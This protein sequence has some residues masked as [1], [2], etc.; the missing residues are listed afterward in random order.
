[1]CI[2]KC[3]TANITGRKLKV[4]AKY[5]GLIRKTKWQPDN[6]V[7]RNKIDPLINKLVTSNGSLTKSLMEL[8][9]ELSVNVLS[10]NLAL[11]LNHEQIL[12]S[13]PLQ[14]RAIVRQ[15]ELNVDENI[16]VFARS[17]LPLSLI[18]KTQ[19]GLANLG[20]KPLGHLLFKKGEMRVSKRQFAIMNHQ[21]RVIF[22]RR[23]PYEYMDST[24]LV[25][26]YFL[27]NV[28]QLLTK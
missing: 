23:T 2:N 16:V 24:I 28:E 25:S 18:K 11:P 7:T 19:T 20:Q 10:Q 15:V 9:T 14:K 6:K 21:G 5:E 22:A 13:R 17:I 1:M 4:V 8:G 27:P 26:E 3:A 12:L